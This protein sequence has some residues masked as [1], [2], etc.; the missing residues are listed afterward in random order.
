MIRNGTVESVY[1]FN[2]LHEHYAVDSNVYSG[3]WVV[4]RSGTTVVIR[5]FTGDE[6]VRCI[7][8]GEFMAVRERATAPFQI[9]CFDRNVP[10]S[11]PDL[12]EAPSGPQEGPVRDMPW[13]I[14]F[15]VGSWVRIT[16]SEPTTGS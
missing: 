1:R 3:D 10:V 14:P 5:N 7:L 2:H 8:I 4:N 9:F 13:T 16:H 12:A 6:H 11:E 15:S